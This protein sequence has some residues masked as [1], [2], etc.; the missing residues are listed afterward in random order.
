MEYG[1]FLK[2]K[3][4]KFEEEGVE[5][6]KERV[7]AD[8]FEFQKDIV[9]WA[10]K[11]GRAAIF[12]DC[13]LGKTYMQLE[14]A[15][16][17]RMLG[18]NILILAPL[19][20]T[21]QTKLEGKKL[22]IAVN[23][24]KENKDIVEGINICNYDRIDK[25]DES[26][27]D[28][29]VLDESSVLKN[30]TGKTK[31]QLILKFKDYKYKLC[32]TATPSPNDNM[33]LLNHSEFLGIM[34]SP[35]A[36]AIWFI[37]DTT[38]LG[39]YRIKKHAIDEF[40]KWVSSWA[41]SLENPS[42]LGYC[43]SGYDLPELEEKEIVVKK[44]N[45]QTNG[46]LFYV[47]EKISATNLHRE[48]RETIG[49]KLGEIKMIVEENKEKS[50]LI[51]C[52]SNLESQELK[53]AIPDSIEIKGSDSPAKKEKA[54]SDFAEGKIKI[55]ISKP[56]IFGLGLNF[57]ICNTVIFT[58]LDFSYELY[59]QALRRTWR[60][61]Q[62]EKVTSYIVIAD[63]EK[64]ILD[65]VR[66]KAK[67]HEEMKRHMYD[68]AKQYNELNKG[69]GY[70]MDYKKD[71]VITNN[72]RLILGDSVEE[73]KELNDESVD[74][75]I[76]SP[77][78]SNLYIY[79]DSYRDMGNN[80]SDNEFYKNFKYLIK[81]LK[82]VLKEGRICAVHVKNLAMYK[83]TDGVTGI[84]NFRDDI[85][86]LFT[87]GGFVYHSE[88]CIWTD[89]VFEMQ[90]TKTQRL[91]YKQLR[92]DASKSGI[93]LA[94][95]VLYFRKWDIDGVS[96]VPVEHF[97][98]EIEV[99]ERKKE[100]YSEVYEKYI[101]E[102]GIKSKET[103]EHEDY[104]KL[105]IEKQTAKEERINF[106][107]Q[108]DIPEYLN[109]FS[110]DKWQKYASPVWFDIL[111]TDVLNKTLARENS[112]EKH[113]CPLQ[114]E[115]IKRPIELFTNPGEIVFTPFMGIGSEV[116]QALNLGR[117]GIGIELKESYFKQ[118]VKYVEEIERGKETPTL[119]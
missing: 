50:I 32:C 82:R 66:R 79:S 8:L 95:Y 70:R 85:C 101:N 106:L 68:K 119:F 35:K 94:E 3:R 107:K 77:P 13:G 45:K 31:M 116:Y 14:W 42:D 80:Y 11:K 39:K 111:R 67:A 62:T 114:L 88:S 57:Q 99:I 12:A 87:D 90:R 7:N 92:K 72:S 93:G 71:E 55:L 96:K 37:N 2:T 91:L 15:E 97:E 86:R 102:F 104:Y 117:R 56:T 83:T 112:D 89:P 51:W 5:L 23:I 115:T 73:I 84:K 26:R 74:F 19:G 4:V 10:L 16:Q 100:K 98:N 36:L 54:A 118:S 61:G 22:G 63:T 60:F 6:E 52:Y 9:V 47:P 41:V 46:T 75:M 43:N 81:D 69:A 78:F 105:D 28:A 48:K 34:E 109:I 25:I 17:L 59:Y 29:I 30:Y 18:K 76:F 58:G 110:L 1:E 21:L 103:P 27:F 53:K 20:V 108:F 49:E 65:I 113:I 64:T 24:I 33:E 44:E 38:N 40:W